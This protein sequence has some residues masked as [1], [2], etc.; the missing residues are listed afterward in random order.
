MKINNVLVTGD[1]LSYNRYSYED[2]FCTNS[3]DSPVNM[4]SWSFKL[5]DYIISSTK[6]FTYGADLKISEF[7]LKDSIFERSSYNGK[8]SCT[9]FYPYKTDTITLYLQKHS[10]GNMYSIDIDDGFD[11]KIV[12]FK[13]DQNYY[14]SREVFSLTFKAKENL[15]C[16]TIK[17]TGS[18]VFTLLGVSCENK[19][20][21]ISGKGSQKV[22]FFL[23]N[24]DDYIGK[25][26]FD[27]ALVI[28]GA[29]DK[30]R[31]PFDEFEKNYV[32]FLDRIT[33]KTK[34]VILLTPSNI[35]SK[36]TLIE[37]NLFDSRENDFY[38]YVEIIKKLSE[39]YGLKYLDTCDLFKNLS[40]EVWR[41]DNVHFNRIGNDLLYK[42]VK[43]ILEI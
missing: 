7:D 23:D 13:G 42:K 6:N 33:K 43:Q 37:T 9:F 41:F 27:T 19:S 11:S 4:K 8:N 29:N 26:D 20:V 40:P 15:D 3:Y 28:L 22:D 36:E 5:R 2:V 38:K 32:E 14:R 24:Y 12:N 10:Y 1:S 30:N 16:H 25:Y 34:N 18:G 39:K 21:I 35:K 31:T 17:F